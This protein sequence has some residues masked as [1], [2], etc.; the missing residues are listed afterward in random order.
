MRTHLVAGMLV[1]SIATAACAVEREVAPILDYPVGGQVTAGPVCPVVQN[2][3]DAACEDRP[4]AGALLLILDATGR[5]FTDIV[6]DSAGRFDVRLPDGSP[7][8]GQL[9]SPE[10]WPT[11]LLAPAET[12]CAELSV[13]AEFPL[14]AP[15]VEVGTGE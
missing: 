1:L 8:V 4:V 3:P 5:Q 10:M 11:T 9:T 2:P 12:G 6:A 15:S 13:L 7:S 14:A